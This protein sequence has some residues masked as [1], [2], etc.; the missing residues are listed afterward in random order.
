MKDIIKHKS[1]GFRTIYKKS[2]TEKTPIEFY[3]YVDHGLGH[4]AIFLT[5]IEGDVFTQELTADLEFIKS[6]YSRDGI[7]S[8][9]GMPE[10][11]SR[12]SDGRHMLLGSD[13]LDDYELLDWMS[14]Y[15]KI[16]LDFK[17]AKYK[18]KSHLDKVLEELDGYEDS[19]LKTRLFEI[20]VEFQT[21]KK[22]LEMVKS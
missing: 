2:V 20:V 4:T 6:R 10:P 22:A 16:V 9:I 8:D 17:Y 12:L 5:D 21:A 7:P 11:Y 3:F 14:D 18:K 19:D 13:Y 1:K 15:I